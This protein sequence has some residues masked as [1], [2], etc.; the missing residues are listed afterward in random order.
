MGYT[1]TSRILLT[2]LSFNLL[3][4]S[5]LIS[6][7]FMVNQNLNAAETSE[8]K[9][10]KLETVIGYVNQYCAACHKVPPPDLM[11]RKDCLIGLRI[12]ADMNISS[13]KALAFSDSV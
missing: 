12:T 5:L 11:P 9:Q 10:K 7:L 8:N 6:S 13:N 3:I 2:I 1:S 4:G